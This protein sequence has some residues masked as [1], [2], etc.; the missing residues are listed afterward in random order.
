MF[1]YIVASKPNNKINYEVLFESCYNLR[2]CDQI[3]KLGFHKHTNITGLIFTHHK[4]N[5]SFDKI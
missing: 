5:D 3:G 1:T 2:I 4:K